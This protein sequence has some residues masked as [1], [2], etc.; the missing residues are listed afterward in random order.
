MHVEKRKMMIEQKSYQANGGTL[1][2]VPTP[3]GNLED[4]TFRAIRVLQEADLIAAE[5]TRQT[6]K[7]TTHFQIET[8]LV[9]YHDHNKQQS[10][11]E[12]VKKLQEGRVVALVSDAGMPGI[13]DPGEELAKQCI[14]QG[15]PVVAL[16]GANAALTTLVA[17]GLS[18]KQFVFCGFLPKGKKERKD[19][20]ERLNAFEETL[21]FYEAP[22][23][24][25]QT[26]QAIHDVF[27][28]RQVAIGREL[29]KKFEEYQRGTLS[30]AIEWVKTGTIKGEFCIA[31]SGREELVE[32]ESWWSA[33]DE[34][35]HVDHY[36]TIGLAQKEAIKQVAKDRS[37]PKRDIYQLYHQ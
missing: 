15:I 28:E 22:H 36:V 4:I 31:V 27:G 9:S 17:S 3:I 12:L 26:L 30:D 32:E 5:D 8:P 7:L 33:L 24:I 1:Y 11:P 18:A 2:L 25:S 14:S 34:I 13:S 20:L 6:R 35:Q 16:P 21:L 23:R 19:E 10:G 37:V 29:T